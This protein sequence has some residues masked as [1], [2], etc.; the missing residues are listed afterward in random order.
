M[1]F[2]TD[3]NGFV[4]SLMKA[5]KTTE[6]KYPGYFHI[7]FFVDSEDTVNE[8]NRRLKEDG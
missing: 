6:V 5:S 2:L 3:G 1:A 4:L 7:G 8:I